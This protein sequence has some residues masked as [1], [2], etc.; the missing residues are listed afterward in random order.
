MRVKVYDIGKI[1]PNLL[2]LNKTKNTYTKVLDCYDEGDKS[3][4]ISE[5]SNDGNL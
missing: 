4:I 2:I 3:I 5:Y 1:S